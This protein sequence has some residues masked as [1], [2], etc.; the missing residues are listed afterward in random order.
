[1]L[2]VPLLYSGLIKHIT[3]DAAIGRRLERTALHAAFELL[4]VEDRGYLD[5]DQFACLVR[6][7]R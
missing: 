6:Q 5:I 4:D 7:L 2:S 3:N 1:M